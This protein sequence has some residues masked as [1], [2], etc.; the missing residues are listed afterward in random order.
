MLDSVSVI[1]NLHDQLSLEYIDVSNIIENSN[2][3]YFGIPNIICIGYLKQYR[4]IAPRDYFFIICRIKS[5]ASISLAKKVAFLF[6]ENK[7]YLANKLSSVFLSKLKTFR[8]NDEYVIWFSDKKSSSTHLY[9]FL[10]E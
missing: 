10:K 6:K 8:F 5:T 4:A 2:Y 7:V 9:G 3:L 1:K